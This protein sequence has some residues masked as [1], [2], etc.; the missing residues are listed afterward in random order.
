[1]NN[2]AFLFC[3]STLLVV[4]IRGRAFERK[5]GIKLYVKCVPVNAQ[6]FEL[7]YCN[8]LR[9]RT[10]IERFVFIYLRDRVV[11]GDARHDLFRCDHVQD[12]QV[13]NRDGSQRVEAA[14][15]FALTPRNYGIGSLERYDLPK[16]E[17]LNPRGAKSS[18]NGQHAWRLRLQIRF[19]RPGYF[20]AQR[21]SACV[22]VMHISLFFW[23]NH[24]FVVPSFLDSKLKA[25]SAMSVPVPEGLFT[26]RL[27]R[28]TKTYLPGCNNEP[29]TKSGTPSF[30]A[31]S[32]VTGIDHFVEP[33]SD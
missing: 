7:G 11:R 20:A 19:E 2:H 4:V 14:I 29:G 17:V 8:N 9:R 26:A 23:V 22:V 31:I 5:V 12:I 24:C 13:F 25:Y 30:F 16:P 18:V 3:S 28:M 1:M 32:V 10:G 33:D 21:H 27:P 15:S 6:V